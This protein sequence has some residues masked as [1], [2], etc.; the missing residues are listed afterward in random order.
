MPT[1]NIRPPGPH[2]LLVLLWSAH[3][4]I[5]RYQKHAVLEIPSVRKVAKLLGT[6]S[7]HVRRWLHWLQDQGY[8]VNLECPPEQRKASFRLLP[9]LNLHR[10]TLQEPEPE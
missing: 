1:R 3:P 6:E 9:P 2:K 4:P 8:L 10:A 7:K 5:V